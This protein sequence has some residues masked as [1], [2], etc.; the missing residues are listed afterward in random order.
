MFAN[1]K[2]LPRCQYGEPAATE[3]G[4]AN[5]DEPAVAVWDW[6]VGNLYVCEKHDEIIAGNEERADG[7][8]E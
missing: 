7:E 4:V 1:R 5:C 2:E 6:G 3:E 8:E